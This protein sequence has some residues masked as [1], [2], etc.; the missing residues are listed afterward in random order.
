MQQF[1]GSLYSSFAHC[2]IIVATLM[3]I[4]ASWAHLAAHHS[5]FGRKVRRR[6]REHCL[7]ALWRQVELLLDQEYFAPATLQTRLL[8]LHF[9]VAAFVIVFGYLGNL[10]SVDMIVEI[11]AA[12]IDNIDDLLSERFEHVEPGVVVNM[13]TFSLMKNAPPSTPMGR[14]YARSV[15][16][17][18]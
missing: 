11:P 15:A 18:H 2:A 17:P 13:F 7:H 4:C 9:V 14:L 8:W 10:L 12:R 5:S 16:K 3:A 1:D 6:F